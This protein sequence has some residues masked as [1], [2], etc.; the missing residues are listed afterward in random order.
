MGSV[1]PS[2]R[3]SP[4]AVASYERWLRAASTPD[5]GYLFTEPRVRFEV[6]ADD[7]VL[8]APGTSEP[9]PIDGVDP[10]RARTFFALLDGE[11]RLA[12]ARVLAGLGD[13]ELARLLAVCFG[14]LLFAPHAVLALE[15]AVASAEI[16]RFPGSPYE[17]PRP[18][19]ANMGAVRRHAERL[20]VRTAEP[21]QALA[22]LAELHVLS[23]MGED[24]KSYYRPASPIAT[25]GLEPGVLYGTPSVVRAT[26]SGPHL[27]SGPKVNAGLVGGESYWR[28]LAEDVGDEAALDPERAQAL[29]GLPQGELVTARAGDDEHPGAWFRP[30]RPVTERHLEALF[31]SLGAARAAVRHAQRGAA[32]AALA[33]FHFRFVRLHPFRAGN[34]SLAMNLVNAVLGELVGA[35]MP[36]L[37]L[38]QLALRFDLTAYRELFARAVAVFAVPGTALERYRVL[39]ERKRSL[40]SLLEALGHAPSAEAARAIVAG[41]ADGARAALFRA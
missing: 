36:H 35:G 34:Q 40:F 8:P 30:P 13:D 6:A 27:V 5:A 37:L 9:A 18:Y 17:I 10:E 4:E 39:T 3:P 32:L 24:Q 11:R 25:K 22:V 41:N 29:D 19:W 33:E 31:S 15:R 14:T 26:P 38:D 23:L 1:A 12:D 7:V 28:L 20:F 2:S 21:R 16:V